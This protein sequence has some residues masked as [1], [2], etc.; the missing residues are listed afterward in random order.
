L[1]AQVLRRW[2]D[3]QVI[4][5]I[6]NLFD[7]KVLMFHAVRQAR[8]SGARIVL[9]HVM[10]HIT[11]STNPLRGMALNHSDSSPQ[12][13]REALDQLVRQ[14]RWEGVSCEPVVLNGSTA[15]EVASLVKHH[16]VDRVIV[17][18]PGGRQKEHSESASLTADILSAL[19]VPV[20]VIGHHVP[21]A[22]YGHKP[23]GRIT[24]ALS[25]QSENSGTYLRFASRL[26]QTHHAHLTLLHVLDPNRHPGP[27]F[28][29]PLAFVAERLPAPALRE[30]G[31]LCRLEIAVREGDPAKEILRYDSFANQDLIIMGSSRS[32]GGNRI[33]GTT[34]LN[35]VV[36]EARC[37]VII[38]RPSSA[39]ANEF[40]PPLPEVTAAAYGW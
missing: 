8:R 32:G 34:I 39:L 18:T 15:E 1:T 6:T 28:G 13:V 36:T 19:E 38:V 20:C 10:R 40:V 12:G 14:F 17:G 4:L 16:G 21:A 9:A 25:L 5:I 35:E 30:A 33:E 26:A 37:P 31:L 27:Q 22:S 2:C 11:S 24:L 29:P 3:P 23:A 7:E